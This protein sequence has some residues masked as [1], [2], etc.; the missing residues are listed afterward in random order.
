MTTEVIG[1]LPPLWKI[2]IEFLALIYHRHLGSEPVDRCYLLSLF[3]SLSLS[4]FLTSQI[5]KQ[6][7]YGRG[8]SSYTRIHKSLCSL[9]WSCLQKPDSKVL[10][11]GCMLGKDLICLVWMYLDIRANT[12]FWAIPSV[13]CF[14][15]PV[16][17]LCRLPS[18]S[19]CSCMLSLL[20]AQKCHPLPIL[21]NLFVLT[22]FCNVLSLSCSWPSLSFLDLSF[23]W[24]NYRD[25]C[26]LLRVFQVPVTELFMLCHLILQLPC[27]AKYCCTL[28]K[29]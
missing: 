28:L 9:V 5:N 7:K 29:N 25:Y 22:V 26:L 23:Y 17:I 16:V 3:F 6:W 20:M 14:W 11:L 1:F 21:T 13:W 18:W 15:T 8:F 4:L 10:F 27:I 24:N 2:W 12:F 19:A